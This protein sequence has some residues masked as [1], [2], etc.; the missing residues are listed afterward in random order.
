M[1]FTVSHV[2]IYDDSRLSQCL[3]VSPG[4]EVIYN[5]IMH[6]LRIESIAYLAQ[7]SG[8]AKIAP[9]DAQIA[10]HYSRFVCFILSCGLVNTARGLEAE[11]LLNDWKRIKTD[12]LAPKTRLQ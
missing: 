3:L 8:K 9:V 11:A 7:G 2:A 6:R 12:Y 1:P 4:G 5:L 10:S